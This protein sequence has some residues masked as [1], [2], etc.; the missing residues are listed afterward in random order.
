MYSLYFD[1]GSWWRVPF[2]SSNTCSVSFF[3]VRNSMST[4]GN[5]VVK[6]AGAPSMM[7]FAKSK[8]AISTIR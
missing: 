2:A 1:A 7:I 8:T 3:A 5:F 4:K 6:I